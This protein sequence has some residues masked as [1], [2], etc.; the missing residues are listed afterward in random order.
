M[1]CPTLVNILYIGQSL[2]INDLTLI[3]TF[4]V[5]PSIT[6]KQHTWI[7][8]TPGNYYIARNWANKI[9]TKSKPVHVC[10]K[11]HQTKIEMLG[12][13]SLTCDTSACRVQHYPKDTQL[14]SCCG[15]GIGMG[16]ND[17][18]NK[19]LFKQNEQFIKT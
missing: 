6:T 1:C 10:L 8:N 13:G 16:W 3:I 9:I 19:G 5:K 2:D 4:E 17:S 12:T 7:W 11:S 18:L 15:Q 14:P